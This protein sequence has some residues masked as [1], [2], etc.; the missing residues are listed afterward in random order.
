MT[1]SD[2]AD[3]T[4]SKPEHKN[5]EH[6]NKTEGQATHGRDT[7]GGRNRIRAALLGEESLLVQC[8]EML[9]H[10]GIEVSVV[11]SNDDEIAAWGAS[12]GIPVVAN[13]EDLGP[14]LARF[15]FDYLFSITNLRIVPDDVLAMAQKMAINFH[16]GPLPAYAGLHAT[17]WAILHNETRHGVSWHVMESG[18][19]R[20][21]LLATASFP[22]APDDTAYTLNVACYEHA[23]SS[24]DALVNQLA[25]GTETRTPQEPSARSYFGRYDRPPAMATIDWASPTDHISALVRGLDFGHHANPLAR[26]R[27]L[28][29]DHPIVVAT[30]SHSDRAVEDKSPGT[31]VAI[32]DGV[33]FVAA[34]DGVVG[35]ATVVN[36]DGRPVAA[37]DALTR[38]GVT[39]G[40]RLPLLSP[41]QADALSALNAEL[42]RHEPAWVSEL[43][44]VAPLDLP[45]PRALGEAAA[46]IVTTDLPLS[47]PARNALDRRGDATDKTAV[48]AA[49]FAC[50]LA[51]LT[52]AGPFHL[53]VGGTSDVD[54]SLAPWI[55]PR[56]PLR[57][58]SL[59]ETATIADAIDAQGNALA[60]AVDRK[61][62]ASDLA[63]RY[64]RLRSHTA[65]TGLLPS[66]G[67]DIGDGPV[68]ETLD[69]SLVIDSANDRLRWRRNTA[70]YSTDVF[71]RMETQFLAVLDQFLSDGSSPLAE[72]NLLT[73]NERRQIVVD[74]ND[75]AVPVDG[76]PTIAAAFAACAARNGQATA[77]VHGSVSLTYADLDARSTQVANRLS[78][79]GAGRGAFVGIFTDRG[80]DMVVALLATLKVGAAYVPLDP[81]YPADRIAFMIADADLSVI[82]SQSTV[83]DQLPDYDGPI[84]SLDD[85]VDRIAALST[86]MPTSMTEDRSGGADLAYLIY[87][88]GSTGTPK[89]VKVTNA[90]VINFLAGMDD[91]IE[92]RSGDAWLTVTSLSFDISVL[93]IFWSLTRG[94]K[95]VVYA[96]E[97]S[98]SIE[99]GRVD[100]THRA[101]PVGATNRPLG[102]S[103]FYFASDDGQSD[104]G[105]KY[106]LLLEGARFADQHGFE[107]VWTP[108]RHFHAFGG[109]YPNPSVTSAAIATITERVKIRAGSCVVPLHH[110]VRVAEEWAVVDNLSKGRVGI[111]FAAGWQ[112]VDFVLKP[113]NF[114]DRKAAVA[115][116]VDI[117]KRLW[118]GETVT[119]D[120]PNGPTD[121]STLPR[122][123]QAELPTW[124]T[125]AG[126]PD[127]FAAAGTGG[128][129][130][131]THLLGQTVDE[132]AEKIG[133]YRAARKAAGHAGDGHVTLMVHTLIGDD[134]DEVRELVRPPMTDY[135]RSSLALIKEAAWSFPTFKQR[136]AD[137]GRSPLD[138]FD[139]QDLNEQEMEALLEHAFNRYFDGSALFGTPESCR[140]MVDHLRRVG[141][142]EVACQVDFGLPA[143]V[144]LSRLPH[145]D[146]LKTYAT[147][148]EADRVEP[149]SPQ[150]HPDDRT[151]PALIERHAITHFQCTPSMGSMLIAD[152]RFRRVAPRLKMCLMGGE[153]FPQTLAKEI[154]DIVDG[155]VLNVY[156]PTETTIWSSVQ[157]VDNGD[158]PVSIGRPLAN[159]QMYVV[160][161][162][163]QPVPLGVPG[164]LLIGGD[165][166]T[167]GYLDRP[168]LTAQ[169]FVSDHFRT[170]RPDA[171]LYRTGDLVRYEANG[172]IEFLGRMDFQV[173]VRGHRIELGEIETRLNDYP[174]IREAVVVARE[175]TPGDQ[176][177]V[178]YVIPSPGVAVD[179][180]IDPDALRDHLGQHLPEFMVP[181]H[182]VTLTRFPLTPNKKTD[183]N[184][185]PPPHTPPVSSG[186]NYVA[187]TAGVQHD[188][189]D[190]WQDLLGVAKVGVDD[191]FFDL[192]GHSLLAVQLHRHITSTLG[193]ELSITDVF[194]FPT[195]AS[196]TDHLDH[197]GKA[198]EVAAAK[199]SDRADSRRQ[200]MKAR[201]TRRRT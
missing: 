128:H 100:E 105:D 179:G 159:Q 172:A 166:V 34:S 129:N 37:A 167:D 65:E 183:R 115:R 178:A 168:E 99:H 162:D 9:R 13:D 123:V 110:P 32:D 181:A 180:G 147:P 24:F 132:L 148:P 88:S 176:R 98:R 106:E 75:T 119:M 195:I 151:I 136:A 96:G 81:T 189:V 131:L 126:N 42:C 118:R 14:S 137:S 164:E 6:K 171:R 170:D 26:A 140:E 97:P 156:G 22:I 198:T 31:V 117:V 154:T 40:D 113:E 169:R 15:S 74:W 192:G 121:V 182:Y 73:E 3:G 72:L 67:I 120:G 33:V 48:V 152:D 44:G 27:V 69:L 91:H 149:S 21:D 127:T 46:T 111:A 144:V 145:L 43:D 158:R 94:L 5:P 57:S 190:I 109:L 173:K 116:D 28:V 56:V 142:D 84:L 11:A 122:P 20:G 201:R 8:G 193:S 62:F 93:E 68:D 102:F 95:L 49:A 79:L 19:D 92:H 77:L 18:V 7:G 199:A 141:V 153:T 143:E 53:S 163:L 150:D 124:L 138:I 35:L 86:S 146:S 59:P 82:V 134:V 184:A 175:D 135:L 2:N 47:T 64:P 155:T 161:R 191:N 104:G 58:P 63:F 41:E 83:V 157:R 50:Y 17:T 71:D 139:D 55:S 80:V 196:L 187:P 12:A 125:V 61:G 39:V 36:H 85:E 90:N 10:S 186:A 107:A 16:D 29:G 188:L 45:Y 38:A 200:A 52:G 78:Q 177:L 174:T 70:S 30:V 194:R 51:K 76:D 4:D 197:R 108:E 54:P 103:L 1:P 112:P 114:G 165:G 89:G 185:L 23:I 66:I 60:K 160:D 130:V 133:V 87:T 25:N 101:S